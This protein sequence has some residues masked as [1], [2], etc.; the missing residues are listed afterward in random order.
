M[1]H[2]IHFCKVAK[3]VH[4]YIMVVVTSGSYFDRAAQ[5]VQYV[6]QAIMRKVRWKHK[7]LLAAAKR[8][9]RS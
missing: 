7:T 4:T 3:V 9:L 5:R 8:D 2:P 6:A 1:I